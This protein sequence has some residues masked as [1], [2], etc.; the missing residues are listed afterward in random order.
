MLFRHT[1]YYSI[2]T[3]YLSTVAVFQFTQTEYT[4]DE[5]VGDFPV[6]IELIESTLGVP[7]TVTVQVVLISMSGSGSDPD[8]TGGKYPFVIIVYDL[9]STHN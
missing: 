1:D 3:L 9:Q 7:I 6:T 5:S 4:A 2:V 8:G